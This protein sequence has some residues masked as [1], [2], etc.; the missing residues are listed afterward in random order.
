MK[1]HLIRNYLT[2]FLLA[3]LL[4]VN[5]QEHKQSAFTFNYS[6]QIPFGNLSN[7]FGNNSSVGGSYFLEKTNNIFYGIE[8]NYLF[9]NNIKDTTIFNNISTSEGAIIGANGYYANV[10]LMQ[11]GFDAYL[12]Y[13]YA[14]HSQNNNLSGIY[15]SQ[16]IGY[17]QH[18]IFID[19]RNQNI[20]QLNEEMKK[21]YDRFSNGIST[22]LSADYKYYSKNGKFQMSSGITL[23]MGHTKIQRTY[24]FAKNDYY[25][26]E[27]KWDKILGFKVEII[28]PINRKN[29]EK[30]HYF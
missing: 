23:T 27:K 20:P 4:N 18:Q 10:N 25:S 3:I 15:L 6:Y 17:L 12:F 2:I 7:T 29:E 13:G 22:K 28:I 8:A 9:G 11:R 16:G 5:G 21:G 14:F 26:S 24:D 19:T 1:K 30:F